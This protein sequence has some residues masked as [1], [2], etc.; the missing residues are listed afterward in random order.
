MRVAR[1]GTIFLAVAEYTGSRLDWVECVPD[2]NVPGV[3]AVRA[4][5]DWHRTG[6]KTFVDFTFSVPPAKVVAEDLSECEFTCWPP[7]VRP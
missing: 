3:F 1:T 7:E 4:Q 5:Q 6:V 2:P